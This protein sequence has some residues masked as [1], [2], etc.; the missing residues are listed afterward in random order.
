MKGINWYV[1]AVNRWSKIITLINYV[2]LK[3]SAVYVK[4]YTKWNV[5]LLNYT[6][7]PFR[8]VLYFSSG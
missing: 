2:S 4:Y 6:K 5:I 1:I 7:F 8:T 3:T